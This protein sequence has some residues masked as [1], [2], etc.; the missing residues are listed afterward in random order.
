VPDDKTG[1]QWVAINTDKIWPRVLELAISGNTLIF[2]GDTYFTEG[3]TATASYNDIM[4]T[5]VV[6]N[7]ATEAVATFEGGV[8][9]QT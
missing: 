8:P 5:S 7:S 4:A 6:I 9:L 1:C 3:Y 2:I